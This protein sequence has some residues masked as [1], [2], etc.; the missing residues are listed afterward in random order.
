MHC[1]F[2]AG[3]RRVLGLQECFHQFPRLPRAAEDRE[4][5]PRSRVGCAIAG[6]FPVV[7]HSQKQV[8]LGTGAYL[9]KEHPCQVRRAINLFECAFHYRA[10][11]VMHE[12]SE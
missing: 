8:V 3:V 4:I 2:K 1:R 6:Y 9:C 10:E 7:L 11:R 12:A 5:L